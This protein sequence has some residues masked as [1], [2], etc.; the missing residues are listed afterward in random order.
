VASNQYLINLSLN[1]K[2]DQT[3]SM[4]YLQ[5]QEMLSLVRNQGINML[6]ISLIC[7]RKLLILLSVLIIKRIKASTTMNFLLVE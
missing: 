4:L 3:P 6:L 1:Q 2:V 7:K 5:V